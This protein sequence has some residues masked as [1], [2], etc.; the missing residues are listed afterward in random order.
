MMGFV[1][2]RPRSPA[3]LCSGGAR[4]GGPGS[5]RRR[6]RLAPVLG[7]W[8]LLRYGRVWPPPAPAGR[9]H[10][11]RVR[12]RGSASTTCASG[13]CGAGLGGVLALSLARPR[14]RAR[15]QPLVAEAR[16]RAAQPVG[17]VLR[18]ARLHDDVGAP[19]GRA[20]AADRADQPPA[21]RALGRGAG[22]GR[23]DRQ[24]H[25]R[26]RDGVLERAAADPDHPV[27]AA[28]RR[29]P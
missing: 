24:V 27:R 10:A 23:H 17:P 20:R 25:G 2:R 26:L 13:T 1:G 9:R 14:R 21:R 6:A 15:P 29:S 16:R 8:A 28:R 11:R 3:A 4:P 18:R 7:A 5:A 19:E 12:R 22:G